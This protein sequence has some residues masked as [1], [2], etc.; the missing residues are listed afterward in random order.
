MHTLAKSKTNPYSPRRFGRIQNFFLVL[1]ACLLSQATFALT[2]ALDVGH[3]LTNS[4]AASARGISEF[5]FNLALADTVKTVLERLGF[6]VLMIGDHGDIT[7]LLVRTRSAKNADFFP[8]IASQ[9]G[10]S[11]IS[12]LVESQRETTSL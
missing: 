4:G 7:D 3:S 9:F 5:Q 10:T 12:V 2:V 8:V 11:T 1:G 6:R